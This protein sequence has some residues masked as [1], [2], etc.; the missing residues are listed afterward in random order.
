[1]QEAPY[2]VVAYV[3]ANLYYKFGSFGIES[4]AFLATWSVLSAVGNWLIEV[5]RGKSSP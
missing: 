5:F 2:L 3:I 1:M 4:L